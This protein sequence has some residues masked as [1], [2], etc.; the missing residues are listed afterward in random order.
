MTTI[1][2]VL[3]VHNGERTIARAIRSVLTQD[4]PHWR[5]IIVDDGSSDGTPAILEEFRCDPRITVVRQDN[6][7]VASARNAGLRAAEGDYVQFLDCDDE[8]VPT[9]LSAIAAAVDSGIRPDVVYFRF[10]EHP[11]SERGGRL[12]DATDRHAVLASILDEDGV[13][14]YI[15]NRAFSTDFLRRE[16]LLFD[17][18]LRFMEDSDFAVRVGLASHRDAILDRRLY[19]YHRS[20]GVTSTP[21]SAARIDGMLSL[22]RSAKALTPRFP[23]LAARCR[24][25]RVHLAVSL[26]L[27]G[28][29]QG[30]MT[31]AQEAHLRAVLRDADLSAVAPRRVR[32]SAWLSRAMPGVAYRVWSVARAARAIHVRAS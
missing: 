29:A 7:G 23:D 15:G 5:L 18:E 27:H 30:R 24:S 4:H 19:E 21:F 12:P 26:L 20:G 17:P 10:V 16:Q 6:A 28:R 3:P 11:R 22:E 8:L 14:G 1:D 25:L 9:A 2:V 31:G 32:F 13:G